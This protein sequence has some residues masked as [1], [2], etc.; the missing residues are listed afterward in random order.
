MR[1]ILM[2]FCLL[3]RA[4]T[5]CA[6][7]TKVTLPSF[8]VDLLKKGGYVVFLRHAR[9]DEVPSQSKLW[10]LD[11]N[12]SCERGGSLNALGESESRRIGKAIK[13]KGIPAGEVL[14]SPT[15][16]TKQMGRIIFGNGFVINNVIAPE[17][18]RNASQAAEDGAALKAILTSPVDVGA[19]RFLISHGKLLTKEAIG[20]D[21]SLDQ[22]EAAVFRPTVNKEAK[23]GFEFLGVIR[24][25]DWAEQ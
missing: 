23:S 7:D 4:S 3:L 2:I 10:E 1:F 8:P 21:I 13:D 19:N 14:V 22:T 24:L 9:R 11:R 18:T 25:N 17:W 5:F 6:A 16:R 15:C 12:S 20:Q